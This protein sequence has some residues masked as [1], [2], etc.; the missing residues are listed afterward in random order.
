[1]SRKLPAIIALILIGLGAML[2]VPRKD[3]RARRS[4]KP[5]DA[6][7]EAVWRMFDAAKKGDVDEYLACFAD[8]LRES[9]ERNVAEMTKRKFGDYLIKANSP[10]LG[11]ALS[12]QEKVDSGRVRMRVE[13]TFR[14]WNEVQWFGLRRKA[15]RSWQI[16][17]MS[18]AKRIKP[19]VPYGTKVTDI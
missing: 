15:G 12:D 19:P 1:M 16:V 2:V 11:I 13:L 14:H 6:P 8:P 5:E 4:G 9:L 18:Q 7:K 17:Q 3:G 10:V